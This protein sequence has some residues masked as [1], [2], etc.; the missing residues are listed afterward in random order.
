MALFFIQITV[1]KL[2][3]MPHIVTMANQILSINIS[4]DVSMDQNPLRQAS[5]SQKK[6]G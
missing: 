1:E 6:S 4:A 3:V 5:C 2:I